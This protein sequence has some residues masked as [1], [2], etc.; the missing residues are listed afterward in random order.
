MLDDT[1]EKLLANATLPLTIGKDIGCSTSA[2]V[3]GAC[4]AN[5]TSFDEFKA[6]VRA[7]SVPTLTFRYNDPVN[8]DDHAGAF[9]SSP[10]ARI[11][12]EGSDLER[13]EVYLNVITYY[14]PETKVQDWGRLTYFALP[15]STPDA[16]GNP[17]S[18]DVL[19]QTR[20]EIIDGGAPGLGKKGQVIEN[21]AF[22]LNLGET[23]WIFDH[24]AAVARVRCTPC[25]SAG[26]D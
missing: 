13:I 19:V 23:A 9:V 26:V 21:N 11:Q 24:T 3:I 22:F 20:V 17:F 10:V 1:N 16:K 7:G 2:T 12:G 18:F 6:R 4:S 8:G 14:G 5:I 15:Q 25:S